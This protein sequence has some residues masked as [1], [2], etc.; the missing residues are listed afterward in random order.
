MGGGGFAMRDVLTPLDRF[1]LELTGKPRPNVCFVPTASGDP[2]GSLQRFHQIF[3]GLEFGLSYVDVFRQAVDDLESFLANQDVVYVGG[4]NTRNM[5]LLWEAWG[6]DRALRFAYERGTILAGVSAGAL[7]WFREGIT[8]SYPGRLV[9]L[10][11]LGLLDGSFSP[12]YDVEPG[13]RPA[14]QQL[15][16]RGELANG[17]AADDGAAL[18]FEGG[19]LREAITEE[20]G[21][22]AYRVSRAGDAAREEPL[23]TR[24][25]P[26]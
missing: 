19:V 24:L 21:K 23:P 3:A 14:F 9:P 17:Y 20:P 7:C 11:C 10:Q 16:A 5:L 4:G 26:A 13:R 25:L 12:H 22:L 6:V 8:D 18:R 2:F 1:V 15:I